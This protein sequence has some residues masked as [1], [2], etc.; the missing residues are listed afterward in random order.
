METSIACS[1]QELSV[2]ILGVEP[3]R[4][5]LALSRLD[6]RGAV[7]GSEEAVDAAVID[8]ALQQN[9]QKPIGTNLG[10]LFKSALKKPK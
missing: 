9:V 10:N 5:R 6:A 7:L 1:G 4:Q 2:R 8:E 3:A